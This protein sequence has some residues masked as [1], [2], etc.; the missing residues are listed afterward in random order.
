MVI[1]IN[2]SGGVLVIREA[3]IC[4]MHSFLPDIACLPVMD[5]GRRRVYPH[6][7]RGVV[8]RSRLVEPGFIC[9]KDGDGDFQKLRN[10][11]DTFLY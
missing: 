2:Y 9:D 1:S 10:S 7:I 8:M 11:E 6:D 3:M 4:E 5:A